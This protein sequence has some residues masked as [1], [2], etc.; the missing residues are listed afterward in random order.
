MAEKEE[1]ENEKNQNE[2]V[3]EKNEDT[4]ILFGCGLA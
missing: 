3:A 2:E 4:A 1:L